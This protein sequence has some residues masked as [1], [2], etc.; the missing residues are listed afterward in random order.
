TAPGSVPSTVYHWV[1]PHGGTNPYTAQRTTFS[2]QPVFYMG[3]DPGSV[4]AMSAYA[5]APVLEVRTLSSQFRA[6]GP[7]ATV[8]VGFAPPVGFQHQNIWIM[9]ATLTCGPQTAPP[10]PPS[11]GAGCQAGTD[12]RGR[13][14]QAFPLVNGL[15]VRSSPQAGSLGNWTGGYVNTWNTLTVE[16]AHT[17][18]SGDVWLRVRSSAANGWVAALYQRGQLACLRGDD[19]RALL[20]ASVV[21]SP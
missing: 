9:A 1:D 17:S 11:G 10:A 16:C 7:R 13:G 19:V 14:W 18:T 15:R 5:G 6:S 2:A 4:A 12:V 21:C 8:G 3:G 20:P